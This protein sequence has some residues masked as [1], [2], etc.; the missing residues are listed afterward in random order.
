MCQRAACDRGT[1]QCGSHHVVDVHGSVNPK[2]PTYLSEGNVSK[3][4]E[5]KGNSNT[6][7]FGENRVMKWTRF[8]FDV[9][10]HRSET[11]ALSDVRPSVDG[12]RGTCDDDDE[13][14][15]ELGFGGIGTFHYDI[16]DEKLF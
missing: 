16:D 8:P 2:I 12:T 15:D 1:W 4:T 13:K 3:R 7:Y 5:L 9:S 10:K 14:D 6:A 11:P